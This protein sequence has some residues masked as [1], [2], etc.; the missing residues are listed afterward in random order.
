MSAG[1][2]DLR[3]RDPGPHR[4]GG[5][6]LD[7]LVERLVQDSLAAQV[8]CEAPHALVRP[9]LLHPL[10]IDV[11]LRVV[12]GR[13]RRRAVRDGLDE[14]R[15]PASTRPGS[16]VACGLVD[17]EH[18]AAVDPHPGDAVAGRLVDEG[19]RPRLRKA[20]SRSPTGCCCRG[21]RA[22]PAS[23][24]RS[25]RPRGT[26]PRRW[27]RRRRRGRRAGCFAAQALAR[28]SGG[29]RDLGRDR[30]ADRGDVVVGRVPPAGRVA[31]PPEST[32]AAGIPRRRP[33]ADSR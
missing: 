4:V 21:A 3:G 16:A 18:V 29:V 17:G 31:A 8:A 13:V 23:P 2:S 11:G 15:P 30:D 26:P 24:R 27:R 12:R 7:L 33:I 10:E 22:A 9:L 25:S 20:A 28:E 19:F 5:L 14:R 6:R 1:G 32:V